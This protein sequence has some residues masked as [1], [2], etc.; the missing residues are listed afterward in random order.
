M[1]KVLFVKVAANSFHRAAYFDRIQ[2]CLFHQYVLETISQPKYVEGENESTW[3]Y[4]GVSNEQDMRTPQLPG[5]PHEMSLRPVTSDLESQVPKSTGI[6][7]ETQPSDPRPRTPHG[8]QGLP[9]SKYDVQQPSSAHQ[10]PHMK[11]SYVS[12]P[13]ATNGKVTTTPEV[14][15]AQDKLQGLTSHVSSVASLAPSQD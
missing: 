14:V 13:G 2:D 11:V 12:I 15:I 7:Y 5:T 3:L 1:A 4:G 8:W 9:S 6:A 10:T